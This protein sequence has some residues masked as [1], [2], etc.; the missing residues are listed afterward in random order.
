ME[1]VRLG[2]AGLRISRLCL[3]MMSFGDPASRPWLLTEEDAVTFVRA[4]ADAGITF[5]DTAD[6]YS[7]GASEEVTGRALRAV[8]PRREDYVLATKAFF[9]MGE[10]P[11]ARGLSRAHLLDAVDASLR[12]LG[13]DH[14][15]LFQV[16]RFDP[17]TP[18]EETMEVLH[19]LVR[20]GK[21]RYIGASSMRAWR[22]ARMQRVAALNGWTEFCSMQD[23][24][25]LLYREEEREMIPMCAESGVAVLPWSPLARGRLARPS[26]EVAATERGRTDQQGMRDYAQASGAIVD[27]VGEVAT[28]RGVSRATVA[29]SWLLRRPGVTAPLVGATRLS[30][31]DDAV[32]ALDLQLTE[33]ENGRLEAPYMPLPPDANR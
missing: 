24:Y 29:L 26:D 17:E 11:N 25:N 30:H 9:P 18:L 13:V 32:A 15:D 8:F 20:V 7:A 27:A 19:D 16:H 3:G 23:H 5:F 14:I 2:S 31:L 10:G 1:Q 33:D 4:A 12:R 6:A 22:F 28:A 21:V